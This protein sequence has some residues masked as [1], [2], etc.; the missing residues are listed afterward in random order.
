MRAQGDSRLRGTAWL[1]V[2]VG[3][4]LLLLACESSPPAPRPPSASQSVP[5]KPSASV[6]VVTRLPGV[7]RL[8]A[9]GDLH[10]DLKATRAALRL[11]GLVDEADRWVGGDTVLVQTGDILD[12]G[13]QERAIVD[14]LERLQEE[15]R[16]AGGAAHVLNGNHELMNVVGDLRYVS[17]QGLREFGEFAASVRGDPAA[18]HVPD[19]MLGRFAAFRPGGRY[20]R[21]L[22]DHPIV[23][24]VGDTVFA[25]G[26]VLPKHVRY[27]IDRINREVAAWLLGQAAVGRWVVKTEDSHT[28]VRHFG[29]DPDEA[30]CQLLGKTLAGLKVVRMVVGHTT[31]ETI[32]PA[33]DQR[34]WAIDVGMA[35]YAG[36]E[37]EVLEITP[38]A[39][40]AIR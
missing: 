14:L 7:K 28:W 35:A 17:P 13:D 21:T 10:G 26:G 29:D 33:C 20:A 40:R 1:T 19:A 11:G 4:S 25:H 27:G 34:V 24:V 12:R 22:A 9:I 23:L 32:T 37:P 38:A 2:L 16:A 30:D 36:G 3:L 15:A 31:K 18:G 39:V 8:V 5:P 6:T